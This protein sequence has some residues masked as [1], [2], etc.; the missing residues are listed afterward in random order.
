MSG[1]HEHQTGDLVRVPVREH[2]NEDS[3]ERMPDEDEGW[4]LGRAVQQAMQLPRDGQRVAWLRTGVA[5]Q[6]AGTVVRADSR[7]FGQL[8]SKGEPALGTSQDCAGFEDDR[9]RPG[10]RA[11][12]VEGMSG[13]IDQPPR[14]EE[15]PPDMPAR[16]L[17]IGRA[18]Y[19]QGE[20]E[21]NE[22]QGRFV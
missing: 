6:V 20:E 11:V 5:P 8:R 1:V 9:G 14:G 12:E 21:G 7:R 2:A 17:L 16:P 10:A 22:D 3:P 18:E 15:G 4:R 19:D 13:D